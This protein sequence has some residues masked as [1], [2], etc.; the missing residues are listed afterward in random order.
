[1]K[2]YIE[3]KGW[4]IAAIL[5][6]LFTLYVFTTGYECGFLGSCR[7]PTSGIWQG[8]V[9]V[10]VVLLLII[11]ILTIGTVSIIDN[12]GF[13][14]K[15]PFYDEGKAAAWEEYQQWLKDRKK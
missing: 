4:P 1:M 15:N 7:Y 11:T 12:K 6:G 9:R 2:E 13:L 14:I 8:L 10:I 5:F 3:I